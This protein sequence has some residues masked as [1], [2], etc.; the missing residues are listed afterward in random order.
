MVGF[1]GETDEDVNELIEFIDEMK[2]D[3]LGA[4]AFS[5]E[6]GTESYTMDGKLDEETKLQRK[7]LV[8]E[9]QLKVSETLNEAKIGK[10]FEVIIDEYDGFEFYTGRTR[11]DAPEIDCEVSFTSDLPHEIGDIVKVRIDNAYEYDLEGEEV[12]E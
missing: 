11:Y 3:R 7:D 4:F 5:D 2:I 9:H 8:M 12:T 1:P 10:V 6:E